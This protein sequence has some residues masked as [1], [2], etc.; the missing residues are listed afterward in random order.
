MRIQ[1][2]IQQ[3]V[4]NQTQATNKETVPVTIQD[5]NVKYEMSEYMKEFYSQIESSKTNFENEILQ[6]MT[7]D[8]LSQF[9]DYFAGLR[10]SQWIAFDHY[11]EKNG[12]YDGMSVEKK[13]AIKEALGQ[14][15]L[16]TDSLFSTGNIDYDLLKRDKFD[17]ISLDAPIAKMGLEYAVV[18]LEKLRD[19]LIPE[20][21]K[22]GFTDLINDYRQSNEAYLKDYQSMNEKMQAFRSEHYDHLMSMMLSQEVEIEKT[23][24]TLKLSRLLHRIQKNEKTFESAG[25]IFAD[26]FQTLVK[27]ETSIISV[28]AKGKEALEDLYSGNRE[29]EGIKEYVD[30]LSHK[31]FDHMEA[32]WQN[33]TDALNLV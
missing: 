31:I 32:S 22:A 30:E 14:I 8:E 29:H 13:E 33:L 1:N 4:V 25:Q 28:M 6:F 21:K 7:V 3:Q 17:L 19:T 11:L 15:T 24:E 5:P 2:I 18:A 10:G 27:D 16:V 23:T 26:V 12:I 20:D 9:D